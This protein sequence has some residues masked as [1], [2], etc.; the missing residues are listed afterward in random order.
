MI[1]CHLA[2]WRIEQRTVHSILY[3]RFCIDV[4]RKMTEAVTRRF[5]VIKLFLIILQ[6]SQK[7]TCTRVSFLINSGL[8][9]RPFLNSRIKLKKRRRVAIESIA[10]RVIYCYINSLD[11]AYTNTKKYIFNWSILLQMNRSSY[12]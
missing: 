1:P 2:E 12:K 11:T 3:I 7:N 9:M 8:Q 5:T 6:N 4:K 10:L